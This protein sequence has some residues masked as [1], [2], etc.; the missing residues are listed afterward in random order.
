MGDNDLGWFLFPVSMLPV[1]IAALYIGN[2]AK[3]AFWAWVIFLGIPIAYVC[4]WHF[5]LAGNEW[6]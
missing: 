1:M 4:F 3:S 6:K 5:G 2:R